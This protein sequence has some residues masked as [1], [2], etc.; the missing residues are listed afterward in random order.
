MEKVVASYSATYSIRTLTHGKT[1]RQDC[2]SG[3]PDPKLIRIHKRTFEDKYLYKCLLFKV[4]FFNGKECNKTVIDFYNRYPWIR[5]PNPQNHRIRI[6]SESRSETLQKGT[7][8]NVYGKPIR[9]TAAAQ[10]LTLML[11]STGCTG[12]PAG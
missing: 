1:K 12:Y 11:N 10:S 9:N 7:T 2:G 5:I 3:N 4:F 6:Q 8:N